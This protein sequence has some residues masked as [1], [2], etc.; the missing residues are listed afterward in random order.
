MPIFLESKTIVKAVEAHLA[1]DTDSTVPLL[2][3]VKRLIWL[4][5]KFLKIG[6]DEMLKGPTVWAFL[7]LAFLGF[8]GWFIKDMVG[9]GIEVTIVVMWIAVIVPLFLVTFAVPSIYGHSG[10][11]Q[12]SVNFVVQHLRARGFKRTNEIELLKKSMKLFEDRCRSRANVL[13][14]LV[15]LLWAGFTYTFLKSVEHSM[16]SPA[17]LVSY[18]FTSATLLAV[19]IIAYLGVWGY[20]A[21]LNKLFRT[22][23]FG[24]NDFCY[25]VNASSIEE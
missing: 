17:E 18:A 6:V 13:K 22:I 10:V 8:G 4:P 16:T 20:D 24:C 5:T 15:G 12:Q 3:Y 25:L 21:A 19:T 23:E 7:S 1:S 2:G 14:W 11:S 9:A